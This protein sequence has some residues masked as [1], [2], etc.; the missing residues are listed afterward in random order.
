MSFK[1]KERDYELAQERNA[2]WSEVQARQRDY[3]RLQA[4]IKAF[5]DDFEDLESDL[6]ELKTVKSLPGQLD[7]LAIDPDL[8]NK[9]NYLTENFSKI[10]QGTDNILDILYSLKEV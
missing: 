8:V 2:A 4:R 6:H 9:A 10:K 5:L 3:Q 7:D 1:Q